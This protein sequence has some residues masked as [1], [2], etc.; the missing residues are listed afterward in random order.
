M[1]RRLLLLL[2]GTCLL[3]FGQSRD[4]FPWWDLPIARDLNLTDEQTQRIQSIVREYR[5][6][7]V[8]LRANVEKSENALSDLVNEEKPDMA[9]VNAAID[10]NVN[11]RGELA[12]NFS[13]MAFRLRMVLTPQQWRELQQRRPPQPRPGLG[14]DGPPRGPRP[15]LPKGDRRPLQD[16][17]I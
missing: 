3:A 9:K 13:Q 16:E 10:R 5:D 4:F 1:K 12:R 11:A 14:P 15:V 6:R 8:D 7:L 17:E 2:L